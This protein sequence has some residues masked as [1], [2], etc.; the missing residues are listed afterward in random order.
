MDIHRSAACIPGLEKVTQVDERSF[1]GTIGATVGPI[2]GKFT[3]RATIVE[4]TPPKE[5]VVQAEGQD[6]VTRS[7]MK[8]AV[9]L[10]LRQPIEN[11][12][13]LVYQA[14][15]EIQGRLAILGDMILRATAGLLLEEFARRL[16]EQ[17]QGEET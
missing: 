16:R 13:E 14:N 9:T 15:V 2:S 11:Q 10:T 5:M 1:D 7:A 4:S 3:F 17:L 12:T 6:S 8:A